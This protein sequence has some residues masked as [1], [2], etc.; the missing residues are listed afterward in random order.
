MEVSTELH[1]SNVSIDQILCQT[2]WENI[3]PA[4]T[5]NNDLFQKETLERKDQCCSKNSC[6]NVRTRLIQEGFAALAPEKLHFSVDVAKLATGIHQLQSYGWPATAICIFD[7]VWAMG[8]E[9]S[10]LMKLATGNTQ[11][12]DTLSFFVD[13]Q[14]NTGFSAHRD[15]QPE[16]WLARGLPKEI[17]STFRENGTARYSTMWVALTDATPDNSC[18]HYIPATADP[19]YYG[20]DACCDD[21]G[22]NSDPVRRVFTRPGGLQSVRA[23]PVKAGGAAFHTHRG[24]HILLR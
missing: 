15:R 18:L 8:Y 4:L 16:D 9:A 23:A 12:I 10:Q 2:Y 17:S 13:P 14:I 20:G 3:C 22:S 1:A 19:G 11:T 21:N 5:I 7:E 6:N 24:T